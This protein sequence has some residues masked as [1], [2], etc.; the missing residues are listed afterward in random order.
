M[1]GQWRRLGLV[2]SA[3]GTVP[4]AVSYSSLPTLASGP[5]GSYQ[6][7]VSPRDAE[8]RSRIARARLNVEPVPTLGAF[9]ATPVVDLGALGTFSDR[10]ISMSSIV[11]SGGRT[12]L[13]YTGWMLG[14]TV[15]FYLAAGLAISDD[16]GL[17]FRKTSAAPL[18]ER[19]DV[20][21]FLTA[22][23]CVMIDNGL[24]RMWYVSGTA[25]KMVDGAPR[26]WYHIKYAESHDGLHWKRWGHV[27]IDYASE[28]E[29]AIARPCVRYDGRLYRMWYPYRGHRYRIGYAES[30]DGLTWTRK[31]YERGFDPSG[32]GWDSEMVEYPWVF[33]SNG[34]EYMLYNGDDYGRAGV[35]LAVWESGSGGVD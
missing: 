12:Y 18:L 8:G 11:S 20:D 32:S 4:W 30:N 10:G 25:W 7:Y 27:C 16:G 26:H 2:G 3:A 9:E 29:Y 15:P 6:L 34:R 13:Y 14:V 21:P 5:D 22:S 23:P 33:E 24:W 1:P 31:D 17:T 28:A 35:G 19:N